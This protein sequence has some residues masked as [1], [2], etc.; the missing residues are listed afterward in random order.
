[1]T[2][3]S[4][5]PAA[6]LSAGRADLPPAVLAALDDPPE[7]E[8]GVVEASGIPYATRAWGE[9]STPPLLLIHGVTSS[10][11]IWWRLGP[12]LVAGLGRRV[13]AIDQAGHGRTGHWTGHHRFRDNAA[14]VAAFIAAAGLGR[15]DLRVVGHSW[16]AMTAAE[17]PGVGVRPE[18]LVLLDPPAIPL[19]AIATMLD[20]PIER[21]YD[22]VDEAIAALGRLNPTWAYGDV[23]AK[24]EALTQFDEAAVR[25]VLTENGDWDGGMAALAGP[26]AAGVPTWLVRG[27]PAHGGLIP[28]EAAAGFIARLGADHVI[29][30]GGGAH[31]PMRQV[32]EATTLALLRSVADDPAWNASEPEPESRSVGRRVASA[33]GEA[34]D[35]VESAAS[36]VGAAVG[37]TARRFDERPGARVR[38][39]RRLGATP[40]PFLFDVHP[41][42]RRRSRRELGIRTIDVDDIKGT[43]V[44]GAQQ[45]GGDFLPL[46]PFRSRNWMGRWQRL[47]RASETLAILPPIDVL[48]LDDGYWVLDGHNRVGMAKYSGQASIDADVTDLVDPDAPP[49]ADPA[50]PAESFASLVEDSRQLRAAVSR[51][52]PP[53]ADAEPGP[54][55]TR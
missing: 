38:R 26:A 24:S 14:D 16:G 36:A 11:R 21:H 5:D 30:I 32:P 12:A 53:A 44:G 34:A 43:A 8:L 3:P 28:D 17:L 37:A 54:D 25:A 31:S 18:V 7:A 47:G 15:P 20:D 19:A 52:A 46:K 48:R 6:P 49:S 10:S 1:V 9:P 33:L 29:T 51:S 35:Y 55:E 23:A 4:A 41:D 40:L 39:V 50:E 2:T 13:V 45:R 22:D 42:A 27:E